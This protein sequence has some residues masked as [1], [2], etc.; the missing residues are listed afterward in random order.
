MMKVILAGHSRSGTTSMAHFFKKLGV[1]SGHQQWQPKKTRC[2]PY[3]L[4]NT[5]GWAREYADKRAGR[6]NTQMPEGFEAD[7]EL[8]YFIYLLHRRLPKVVWLVTVRD[9]VMACNSLRTYNVKLPIEQIARHYCEVYLFIIEQALRMQVKPLL[10]TFEDY[11]E[12]KYNRKLAALFDKP[13]NLEAKKILEKKIR[14]SGPY[15]VHDSPMYSGYWCNKDDSIFEQC[16]QVLKILRGVCLD[17]A[18]VHAS[19]LRTGR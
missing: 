4:D 12:G 19:A 17:L 16:T 1:P 10:V 11:I 2:I 13:V 9:P 18:S 7:W 6:I 15:D 5:P 3:D 14:T 8:S